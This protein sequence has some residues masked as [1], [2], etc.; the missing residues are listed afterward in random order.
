MD[1]MEE[2]KSLPPTEYSLNSKRNEVHRIKC[3]SSPRGN[4]SNLS[5]TSALVRVGVQSHNPGALP[6]GNRAGSPTGWA[7]QPVLRLGGP[8]SRYFGWVGPTADQDGCGKSRPTS[9]VDNKISKWDDS[10][11]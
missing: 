10:L 4:S 2:G 3:Y 1:I 8:L 6:P 11:R 7:P 5:L 9:T